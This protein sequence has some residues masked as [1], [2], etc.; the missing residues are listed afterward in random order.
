MARRHSKSSAH[1]AQPAHRSVATRK[2]NPDPIWL[3]QQHRISHLPQVNGKTLKSLDLISAPEYKGISLSFQ[4]DT[5]LDFKLETFFTL[6]ADYLDQRTG[7]QRTLK[8][9]SSNPATSSRRR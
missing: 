6:K 8:T 2:T 4:D 3:A 1:R 7:K 9:W 5:F